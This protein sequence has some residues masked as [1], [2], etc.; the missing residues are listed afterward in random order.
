MNRTA[1]ICRFEDFKIPSVTLS[2]QFDLAL[3]SIDNK[4]R[5]VNLEATEI[6]MII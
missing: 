5:K 6:K 4:I 3:Q 1:I 2:Q